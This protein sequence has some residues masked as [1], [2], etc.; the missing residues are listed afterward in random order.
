MSSSLTDRYVAAVLRGVPEKQRSDVEQELRASVADAVDGMLEQGA[1]PA[2]AERSVLTDLGDPD[3]LAADYSDRPLHLIGPALFLDYQRLLKLLLA[4]VV[5]V[6][7]IGV[8]LGR[9]LSGGTLGEIIAGSVTTGLSV[10]VHLGF[11]VTFVFAVLER[12]G[13]GKPVGEWSLDRLPELPA[14]RQSFADMVAAVT[15]IAILISL[16]FAQQFF[17][18]VD[19]RS[20]PVLNPDNWSL[21]FPV[22]LLLLG[23]EIVLELVRYRVGS[24]TVPLAFVNAVLNVAVAVIVIGLIRAG[25]LLND[26]FFAAVGWPEGGGADGA[27]AVLGTIAMVVVAGFSIVDAF[28]RA[29]RSRTVA[30]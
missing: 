21:W 18:I 24:W 29:Y 2:T 5:P 9:T 1:A 22:L 26:R 11:W 3:R 19:G 16:L 14:R 20:L 8:A 17:V 13:A 28:V 4:I 27:I 10:I 6:S 25:T 15:W 23:A 30:R 12:S 7:M